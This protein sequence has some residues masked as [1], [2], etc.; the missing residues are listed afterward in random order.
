MLVRACS[1]EKNKFSLVKRAN[2][3]FQSWKHSLTAAANI[4]N[5][6]ADARDTYY[7]LLRHCTCEI[8]WTHCRGEWCTIFVTHYDTAAT[9]K[10][11][12]SQY[13]SKILI[14]LCHQW[15]NKALVNTMYL[16]VLYLI[17]GKQHRELQLKLA[18]NV[19]T[20]HVYVYLIFSR[21]DWFTERDFERTCIQDDT[22]FSLMTVDDRKM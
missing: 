17:E 3:K 4:S 13:C 8:V 19:T 12:C 10:V 16:R 22:L 11:C 21:F 15:A 2:M 6:P 7:D 18:V 9:E 20:A 14:T 5:A 1:D